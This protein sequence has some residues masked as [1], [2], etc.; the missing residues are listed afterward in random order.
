MKRISVIIISIILALAIGGGIGYYF[1]YEGK[2]YVKTADAR[3]SADM[4]P[5]TPQAAGIISAWNVKIGDAVTQGQSVGTQNTGSTQTPIIAPLTGTVIQST[6]LKG[7]TAAPGTSL[8]M[9]ANTNNPYITAN[10]KET[11]ITNIQAGQTVDISVDAYPDK[12]FSGTVTSIGQAANSTFSLLPAQNTSG[13]YT[14][15]TQ[16]IPISISI[17][18]FKGATLMPGMNAYVTVHIR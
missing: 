15:V 13:T 1:S 17:N 2:Y 8:G 5:I 6:A 4:L 12:G 7:Q 10:I 16:L 11:D 9:V 3:V 18:D 14:K